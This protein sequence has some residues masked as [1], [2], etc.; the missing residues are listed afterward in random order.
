MLNI[1]DVMWISVYR[2]PFVSFKNKAAL[3]AEELLLKVVDI[4]RIRCC[5]K[6]GGGAE[7]T[8]A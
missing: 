3:R 2:G 8:L 7:G 5:L 6:M 4:F 1:S